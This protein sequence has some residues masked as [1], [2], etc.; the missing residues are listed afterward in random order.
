MYNAVLK[1]MYNQSWNLLVDCLENRVATHTVDEVLIVHGTCLPY[2]T[3]INWNVEYEQHNLKRLSFDIEN[4][5][6]QW[7]YLIQYLQ[8]FE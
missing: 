3:Y 1:G 6:V 2:M 8:A 5:Y 7:R 4:T